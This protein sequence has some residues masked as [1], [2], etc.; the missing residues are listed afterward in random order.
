MHY[1]PL[2]LFFAITALAAASD[3]FSIDPVLESIYSV[4]TWVVEAINSAEPTAWA[5]SFEYDLA[6]ESSV[7]VAENAGTMP[8]W[9]SNLPESVQ[10][11]EATK[12]AA[13][14]SYARTATQDWF[15]YSD[16]SATG[17]AT[18]TTATSTTATSTTATS[19]TATSTTATSTTA[20]STSS[21]SD[22]NASSVSTGGAP[23]ASS[24]IF[25]GIA[26][27]AGILGL[28]IAL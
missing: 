12:A 26:G 21:S 4:P 5:S 15:T 8:A 20:T 2:A 28:A 18:A 1:N 19:T 11:F 10:V 13:I 17:T 9:Y 3:E 7:L 24:D 27:A 22:A 6:F 25:L 16:S 14:S 23:T